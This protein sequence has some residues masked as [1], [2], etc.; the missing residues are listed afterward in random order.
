MGKSLAEGHTAGV[1]RQAQ[2]DRQPLLIWADQTGICR[3]SFWLFLDSS[4][5]LKLAHKYTDTVTNFQ[6]KP[7]R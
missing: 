7:R 2:T 6:E 4:G 1:T 3:Q 5:S